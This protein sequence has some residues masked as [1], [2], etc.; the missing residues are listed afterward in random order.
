MGAQGH[1]TVDFG[2][3]PGTA[4]ARVTI[5]GETGI[6]A[7]SDV[8][9]WIRCEAS[10]DH[11]ADEHAIEDFDVHAQDISAGSGFLITVRPRVGRAYGVFNVSWVWN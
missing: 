9:A 7:A 5:T 3:F 6:V 2:V 4:E 11:S 10:A 8:E 1:T